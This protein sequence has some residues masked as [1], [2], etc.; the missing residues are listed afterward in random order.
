MRLRII[1][2]RLKIK[3]AQFL[4]CARLIFQLKNSNELPHE[5]Q[6]SAG[7]T[8]KNTPKNSP[9]NV[10]FTNKIVKISTFRNI[11]IDFD[12]ASNTAELLAGTNPLLSIL[13]FFYR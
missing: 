11:D 7:R 5:P 6:R 13:S 2:H 3:L 12:G 9:K 1:I 4:T 10:N 8:K